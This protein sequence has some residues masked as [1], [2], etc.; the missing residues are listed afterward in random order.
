MGGRNLYLTYKKD[1]SRLL[2]WVINT[3]NGIVQAISNAEDCAPVAINTTGQSTVSEIVNMSK[4]IAKHVQPIPSTIFELFQAVIKARSV[5]YE[6]FQRIVNQKPDPEIEKSNAT[7][8]HF[9]NALTDAFNA[10]GGQLWISNRS[11]E[12][13]DVVNEEEED[14]EIFQNQFSKL[15]LDTEE[16]DEEGDI[17]SDDEDSQPGTKK[18]NQEEDFCK[19]KEREE[20]KAKEDET[21]ISFQANGGCI[22]GRCPD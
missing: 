8:K 10:L 14:D 3:S 19:G 20:G 1:T 21:E 7:H 4:L 12:I 9:I 18:A 15:G 13:G 16:G 2:Y 6:A 17:S 22:A 5:T 11:V